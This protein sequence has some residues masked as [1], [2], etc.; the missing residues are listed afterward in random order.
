MKKFWFMLTALGAPFFIFSFIGIPV[1]SKNTIKE[2]NKIV[3][4]TYS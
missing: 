3:L 2:N 1:F 4:A